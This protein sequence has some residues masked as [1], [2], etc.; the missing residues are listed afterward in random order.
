MTDFVHLHVHTEYSLLDGACRIGELC[1]KAA[2][3]G[4]KALAITDHGVMYG[5]VDFYEA[6]KEAGIKPVL[7]C[8]VYTAPR[9]R[10]DRDPMIDA[11]QG[12]LILL[13][14]N[15]EGYHNLI[16]IVSASFTE[17]FYYKPRVDRE[18]LRKYSKGLIACSACIKGDVAGYLL[19]GDY[20]GAK[21]CALEYSEIFGP[22]NFFLELQS[23]GLQEQITVNS[24][25]IRISRETGLPLVATNDVHYLDPDDAQMQ[26]VLM[27]I[28]TGKKLSDENR[29][30]FS[31]NTV[32][33]RSREE[34]N[35]LFGKIPEALENTC[36]I[37]DRC[38]VE[39]SF[40][41]PVLPVFEIPG[42]LSAEE[43]LR[44]LSYEG[45]YERYGSDPGSEV[46][47][48]LEYE[49][50][51]ISRMGYCEY[52]LIVWDFI[53]YAKDNGI[54]VGPG[55]GSGAGSIA[56]YC[57][58]ITN[59]DPLK[60]NLAF[61]RF[62]N[63]ERVSMPDFD[64]D[65]SDEH[66]KD[67]I[68]YV[69]RKYGED[70]V[71]QIVTFGT[72]AA[73][74]A[75]RDVGRV[76]DVP[77]AKVDAVAK[78]IP[79][80]QGPAKMSVNQVLESDPE[81][82]KLYDSDPEIRAM[83][84]TASK[85]EGM[86]RNCSTHAAGVVLTKR[87]VTDYV[88]VHKSGDIVA[89]QFPMA[90][91]E[92]IGLLK[93]DFLGLRTL[94]VIQ[95]AQ[96][97]ILKNHGVNID[98]DQLPLN[99]PKVFATIQKGQTAGIFQLESKGM[100]K[101]MT[102]LKP[103]SLEDIIA[104]IA[105]YRPGPIDQI[106]KYIENKKAPGSITYDDE[107]LKPILDVTYGCMVYQEQVMQIF[108]DLAGYT[109][110]ASDLVRR[111]MAKKKHD[112]MAKE[113]EKFIDGARQHGVPESAAV[114]IFDRM[115]EFA[116][117]AFNK[118]HA[119]CYAVVAYETAFL[120]TYYP[121]EFMAGIMN[122]FVSW[123]ERVAVYINECRQ[124]KIKILPPD[125]NEGEVRF[126]VSGSGIVYAL[127]AIKNVG[128]KSVEQLC[129]VR[130]EGGKFRSFYDFCV[131]TANTD[132]NKRT[133]ES[134]IKAG[135]FDSFGHSRRALLFSYE[136]LM[137][138]A[139]ASVRSR[140]QGQLSLFD[141]SDEDNINKGVVKSL[142]E[143]DTGELLAMEKSVLGLYL[144]GHPLQPYF[145]NINRMC[146]LNSADLLSAGDEAGPEN[147]A[148]IAD[149]TD[150][151]IAGI[152]TTIKKKTTK[153]GSVMAFLNVEDLFGSFEVIL[154][155]KTYEKFGKLISQ[156]M[157]AVFRGKVNIREDDE[158][159]IYCSTV[160]PIE[161]FKTEND[162]GPG[163]REDRSFYVKQSKLG[164]VKAFCN[165][166]TPGNNGGKTERISIFS[167]DD[168]GF[169]SETPVFNA[170]IM[171]DREIRAELESIIN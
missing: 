65:F 20:E 77:Y 82:K 6:C 67:V 119:A 15:D 167:V 169:R 131:R 114:K 118:A 14:E 165:F 51:I 78:M 76:M 28:Q 23:N 33:L 155:P 123:P 133:V 83:I 134:L 39:I 91:L 110:G 55:R 17:G 100:T 157:I 99:D 29:M 70:R 74:A 163:S 36:R 106:P 138:N 61:E 73:R 159:N 41:R 22:D 144:T 12:H 137:D 103:D 72:L 16:K 127:G 79:M 132:I 75:I 112:V 152:I 150:V 105:L 30:K 56:A 85:I 46:I 71:A 10:F 7:G 50:G 1:R 142:S 171:F 136:E 86:P 35:D 37:A 124:M 43:Y 111:A 107:K 38:N 21:K 160:S 161:S 101:F 80:A 4:M 125:V 59:I 3:Y 149:G 58:K 69:I 93:I 121:S 11:E 129:A 153:N 24:G 166:F 5:V 54:K 34:M 154:F 57:L 97:M 66:R 81:F 164:A 60:F 94:S 45:A 25:L 8:E 156:D 151:V 170:D 31:T 48:R 90:V 96:E 115:A 32:Y 89:T 62:L 42:G 143:F 88:P 53:K 122:S 19:S 2:S 147:D 168:N 18:L 113:R 92:K 108:R 128:I 141:S 68:D 49:L 87:P 64:V 9:S 26:D 140:A 13:A 95:D 126:T 135:A 116:S 148:R 52:Y 145:Q 104:G 146:T 109:M 84:D 40:G 139:S 27:C 47:K 44:K 117:Y 120:K 98:F 63:P 158:P 130:S 102:E 162:K